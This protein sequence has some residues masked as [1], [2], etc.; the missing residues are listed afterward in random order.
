M[1]PRHQRTLLTIGFHEILNHSCSDIWNNP[2]YDVY[3]GF[4]SGHNSLDNL[5]DFINTTM[6]DE[7]NGP[8]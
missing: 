4:D 1:V 7:H 5:N 8:I 3:S 2:Y 6:L